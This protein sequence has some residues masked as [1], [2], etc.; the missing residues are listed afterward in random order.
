MILPMTKPTQEQSE[1]A[2]CALVAMV[3]QYASEERSGDVLRP[4]R[5][6]LYINHASMQ[7]GEMAERV[8]REHGILNDRGMFE[9]PWHDDAAI[10]AHLRKRFS[11]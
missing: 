4:W 5:N 1:K 8:L 3:G 9:V 11:P 10:V 7:A 2:I 6:G